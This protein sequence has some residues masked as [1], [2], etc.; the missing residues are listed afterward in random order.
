MTCQSPDDYMNIANNIKKFFHREGIH[1]TTIQPEFVVEG[2]KD[3]ECALECGKD[4]NCAAQKCCES[5][6]DVRKRSPLSDAEGL[7]VNHESMV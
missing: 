1:S 6:N 2:K 4:E 7:L 3:N 5:E